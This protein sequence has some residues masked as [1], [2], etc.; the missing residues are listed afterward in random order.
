MATVSIMRAVGNPV[1]KQQASYWAASS[2][3]GGLQ[4]LPDLLQQFRLDI[5]GDCR[6]APRRDLVYELV[7]CYLLETLASDDLLAVFL[8]QNPG[9]GDQHP[10]GIP[11]REQ[12]GQ[13]GLVPVDAS[14][15]IDTKHGA[16]PEVKPG[17]PNDAVSPTRP[18]PS[19]RMIHAP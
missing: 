1:A 10:A 17:N 18:R 8:C 7:H 2:P 12:E 9:I 11:Q 19:S 4:K 5:V 14:S 13:V 16:T 6:S 15:S 3:S